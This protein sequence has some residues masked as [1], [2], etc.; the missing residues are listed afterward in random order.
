MLNSFFVG[1]AIID[2]SQEAQAQ[3][4]S[5]G[6]SNAFGNFITSVLRGVIAIGLL[7]VLIFL[8]MGAFDW[9]S[10]GGD[11]GKTE[12]ARNKI[13]GAIVGLIVLASTLALFVA[14][15]KFLGITVFRI[16]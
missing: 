7:L 5:T 6:S 13:T 9:I 14:I 8:I 15:Q 3:G 11:K 16:F 1:P 4:L 12:S 2:L 10:G